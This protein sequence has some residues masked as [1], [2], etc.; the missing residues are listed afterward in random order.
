[1]AQSAAHIADS[2]TS[3]ARRLAR[4][5]N[6]PKDEE[7]LHFRA[8]AAELLGIDK[9]GKKPA[10]GKAKTEGKGRGMKDEG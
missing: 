9:N 8:E 4:D 6:K 1:M 7:L 2:A 3:P 5:E 10:V